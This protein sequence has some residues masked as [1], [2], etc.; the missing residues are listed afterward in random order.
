MRFR[1]R[2][3]CVVASLCAVG[4]VLGAPA[5]SA[6]TVVNQGDQI[7]LQLAGYVTQCTVGYVD[8]GRQ[9]LT[10]AGH[11]SDGQTGTRVY[12]MHGEFI[13]KV[14]H[15]PHNRR[16]SDFDMAT[17]KLNGNAQA[18]SNRFSGN[19]W[20]TPRELSLGEEACTYSSQKSTIYCGH[21]NHISGRVVRVSAAGVIGGDSGGPAWVPGRGFIGVTVTVEPSTGTEVTYPDEGYRGVSVS[22]TSSKLQMSSQSLFVSQIEQAHK[23]ATQN[24][25][26][27]K[28]D[29]RSAL[30]L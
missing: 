14:V 1:R 24:V 22:E 19:R 26:K 8:P 9:T 5:A 16:T 12:D 7:A 21:I 10:I 13:G 25:A 18:G 23:Q 17:V 27:F 30:K 2:V 11:C 3:A 6:T 4:G 29:V 20:I 28:R 15:N